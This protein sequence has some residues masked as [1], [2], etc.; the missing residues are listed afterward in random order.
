MS[1]LRP[2]E[3]D[4]EL[5]GLDLGPAIEWYGEN[6]DVLT[7]MITKIR[8]HAGQLPRITKAEDL[9]TQKGL[10]EMH[11]LAFPRAAQERRIKGSIT[12]KPP[13]W[14]HK[15]STKGKPVTT[16]NP[17]EAICETAIVPSHVSYGRDDQGKTRSHVELYQIPAHVNPHVSQIIQTQGMVHEYAHTIADAFIYGKTDLKFPNGKVYKTEAFIAEFLELTRLISPMSEYSGYYRKEDGEYPDYFSED[18]DE[19]AAFYFA[20]R[21]ELAECIA[22]YMLGFVYTEDVNR[23]FDPFKNRPKLK[24]L[25]KGFLE[26]EKDNIGPID[27]TKT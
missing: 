20:L 14:F 2:N 26:A 6:V 11:M 13:L 9:Q 18:D 19:R 7:E 23:R 27:S 22:A 12:V 5:K 1:L 17:N 15:D 4:D 3:N 24:E 16:S 25:I 10:L 8:P 21:E